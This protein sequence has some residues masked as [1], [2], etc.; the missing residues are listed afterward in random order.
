MLGAG[1]QP[2]IVFQTSDDFGLSEIVMEEVVPGSE[3]D[4]EGTVLQTWKPDGRKEQN[5]TWRDTRV[6]AEDRKVRA[7]RI[8]AV[9]NGPGAGPERK[10]RSR[11]SATHW[12]RKRPPC[13][14]R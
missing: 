10:A 6:T 2:E 14:P 5:L 4:T 9:D 11:S 13:W 12:R 1:Q 3:R 8:T 7:Y